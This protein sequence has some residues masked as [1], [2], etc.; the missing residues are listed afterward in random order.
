MVGTAFG[1][2]GPFSNTRSKTPTASSRRFGERERPKR[3]KT[4]P[5]STPTPSAGL[6]VFSVAEA[7]RVAEVLT[8]MELDLHAVS[9]ELLVSI[10]NDVADRGSSYIL[11]ENK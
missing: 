10:L 5:G 3:A 1:V 4:A 6:P 8:D 2:L 7:S 11:D 9:N